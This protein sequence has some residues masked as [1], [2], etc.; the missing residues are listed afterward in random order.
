MDTL[1]YVNVGALALFFVMFGSRFVLAL[2]VTL[3]AQR[4]PGLAKAGLTLL[5]LLWFASMVFGIY[6]SGV[7][8]KWWP[9]PS[10]CT[11]GGSLSG[12]PDLSK[13]VV[14]SCGSGITACI[15]ALA[16]G[17][18]SYLGKVMVAGVLLAVFETVTLS[19]PPL[20]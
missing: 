20:T 14:A 5:V 16:L 7:E 1:F 11:G 12:L 17:I 18:L 9:G 4:F 15:L 2:V 3:L 13:P 6:H 19:A 10:T 8:W